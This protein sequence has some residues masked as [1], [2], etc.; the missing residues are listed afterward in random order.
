MERTSFVGIAVILLL[1][2]I[3]LSNDI[4]TLAGHGFSAQ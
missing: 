3:G 1:L 4:S 2:V